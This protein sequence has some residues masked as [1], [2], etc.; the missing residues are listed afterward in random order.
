MLSLSAGMAFQSGVAAVNSSP[1]LALTW[2]VAIVLVACVALFVGMLAV[3]VS[4]RARFVRFARAD[5]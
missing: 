3:E 5:F 4:G 2:L 1:H